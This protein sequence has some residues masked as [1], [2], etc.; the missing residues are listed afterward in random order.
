M[1]NYSDSLIYKLCCKDPS[2]TD[3]YIG[4]TTNKHR[5]K[6]EH[7]SRCNNPNAKGYNYYI[8]QFIRNN[9]N[10]DNWD[11]IIIEEYSCESKNQLEMRERYWIENLQS[12]L[13]KIIPTRTKREYYEDNR[14]EILKCE[15]EYYENNK[16]EINEK[17][18]EKIECECGCKISRTNIS[19]H[20]KSNKHLEL[21]KLKES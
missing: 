12:T 16:E 13:N 11:M 17:K 10:F 21:M 5:R 6:Q 8:Y 20:K 1:V 9:G 7:K 2:I 15:K 18:N 4:S 3:I 19:T 14:E